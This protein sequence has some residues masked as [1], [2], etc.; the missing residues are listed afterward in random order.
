MLLLYCGLKNVGDV[1]WI[2]PGLPP[3]PY[4]QYLISVTM[5]KAFSF[6]FFFFFL[7]VSLQSQIVPG[8][9]CVCSN[10]PRLLHC[11]VFVLE[12]WHMLDRKCGERPE[13]VW[14]VSLGHGASEGLIGLVTAQMKGCWEARAGRWWASQKGIDTFGYRKTSLTLCQIKILC[15]YLRC[16]Q[17]AL[18]LFSYHKHRPKWFSLS[19]CQKQVMMYHLFKF[20]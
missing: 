12:I 16:S 3:I 20:W 17:N 15:Y 9:Y 1:C 7:L 19:T 4:I 10:W 13:R 11:C 8:S 2:N 14:N 6:F 18:N 5:I